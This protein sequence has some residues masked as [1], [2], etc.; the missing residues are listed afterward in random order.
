M[1]LT[2]EKSCDIVVVGAG[3]AGLCAAIQAQELGM[4]VILLE[5]T[6][7]ISQNFEGMFAVDS[8]FQQ[9]QG[10]H[11][12]RGEMMEYIAKYYNYRVNML[13]WKDMIDHSAENLL[14]LEDHGVRFSGKVDAFHALGRFPT[15]HWFSNDSGHFLTQPLAEK[16]KEL[17]VEILFNTRGKELI[18]NNGSVSGI[19]A[20]TGNGNSLTI[21]AKAVIL[22]T[23]GF[24]DNVALMHTPDMPGFFKSV[25]HIGD[26]LRMALAAGAKDVTD[27]VAGIC[28]CSF[29]KLGWM[30]PF[31]DW[32]C[33]S[34]S[35]IWI[36]ETGKRFVNEHC[37]DNNRAAICN[38]V[39]NQQRVYALFGASNLGIAPKEVRDGF[40]MTGNVDPEQ[41]IKAESVSELA[42]RLNVP[43]DILDESITR[44]NELCRNGNDDDFGKPS[45]CLAEIYPP[46]YAGPLTNEF[47]QSIGGIGVTRSAEVLSR[48][49]K[50]IPG[51]YAAGTDACML[52][53]KTYS[54][55]VPASCN[56]HNVHSGR[57]AAQTAAQKIIAGRAVLN[58]PD[59]IH[60][61]CDITV[62]GAGISGLTAALQAA[63]LGAKVIV[64]EASSVIS[65]QTEGLFAVGSHYQKQQGILVTK[66]EIID[67]IMSFY[68]Y[69]LNSTFWED[70]INHSAENLH[71]LESHGAKFS[72]QVDYYYDHGEFPVFHWFEGGLG[73]S[74]TEP[75]AE[76]AKSLGVEILFRTRGKELLLEDGKVTGILAEGSDGAPVAVHSHSVILTTGCFRNSKKLFSKTDSV[77]FHQPGT[78]NGDGI[79]MA[80]AIGAEDYTDRSC[81]IR[82]PNFINRFFL[83]PLPNWVNYSGLSVWINE[84]GERFINELCGS[85][86]SIC[87]DNALQTQTMSYALFGELTLNTAPEEVRDDVI[88]ELKEQNPSF[89]KAD[90]I[91]ELAEWA[92]I[93]PSK[94]S[95]MIAHYN[96]LCDKGHDDDFNKPSQALVR[97]S[98]PYYIGTI[99]PQRGQPIGGLAVNLNAAV[100]R[101]DGTP[102]PGLFAAG[103]DACMLYKETYTIS[104]P[105]SCN[106][107]NVHSGRTAAKSAWAY[108]QIR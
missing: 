55:Q 34:G 56:G 77:S 57:T 51:L 91:E 107:H 44:Y 18:I 78:R 50:V 94:L 31:P 38:S 72:G 95:G 102:I 42:I 19:I 93:D 71:W 64:L 63:E 33:H 92:N 32:V 47:F 97:L 100:L 2:T 30:K 54:M 17:G 14:W 43:A 22:S 6:W 27:E 69:R 62:I 75:L 70:M 87:I 99:R 37:A 35:V 13:F 90:S 11:I 24:P 41:I 9:E 48:D 21:Y 80:T 105:A 36:N 3:N 52:Y 84:G 10:I 76:K 8:H 58:N 104:I 61:T 16:A 88:N 29:A 12:D 26:G 39:H 68:N 15:F 40:Q 45:S 49:D 86:N 101:P 108:Q 85:E 59:T 103:T 20:K 74:L 83:R 67:Y 98:P 23:G 25:N 106:G 4:R 82:E 7:T 5:A 81:Y 46:Y 89:F 73:S 60:K 1:S 53:S 65:K 28:A 96:D 66:G 79:L